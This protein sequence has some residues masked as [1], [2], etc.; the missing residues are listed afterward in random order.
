MEENI[1][2]F[3]SEPIPQQVTCITCILSFM[4]EV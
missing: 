3:H 4:Q 2:V 1:H